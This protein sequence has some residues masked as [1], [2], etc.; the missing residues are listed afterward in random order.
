MELDA[1]SGCRRGAQTFHALRSMPKGSSL[2][3]VVLEKAGEI[4]MM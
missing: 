2:E 1:M 3:S 4:F